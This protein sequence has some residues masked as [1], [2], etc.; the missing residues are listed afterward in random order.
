MYILTHRVKGAIVEPSRCPRCGSIIYNDLAACYHE[1][2]C[3]VRFF[4]LPRYP[5]IVRTAVAC[6]TDSLVDVSKRAVWR[7]SR[8][9]LPSGVSSSYEYSFWNSVLKFSTFHDFAC[10]GCAAFCRQSSM[11]DTAVTTRQR[12]EIWCAT[13]ARS[14]DGG[15]RVVLSLIG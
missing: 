2:H 13:S 1:G 10:F 3:F 14:S 12:R 8:S 11:L 7:T 4:R 9:L 6:T 5:C 15:E